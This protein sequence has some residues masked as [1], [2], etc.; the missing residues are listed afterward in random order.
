MNKTLLLIICDFLLLN[1]LALTRWE[2][3]E[4]AR[5]LEQVKAPASAVAGAVTQRD[6]L[7]AVMKGALE[8]EQRERAAVASRLDE[9]G[10]ALAEREQ[11]LGRVQTEAERLR[12]AKQTLERG[13]AD[14]SQKVD[15]ASREAGVARER[16]EAMQR[17]MAVKEAELKR[18]AAAREVAEKEAGEA[19]ARVETLS[20]AVKV[21]EREKALLTETA[22]GLRAQVEQERVERARVQETAVQLAQGVGQ[23]AQ[24]S[25]E[26]TKEVR[27]NRVLS[28][29]VVFNAYQDGRVTVRM[30]ASRPGLLGR[31][32]RSASVDT[33]LVGDGRDVHAL[34]HLDETPF[35][36]NEPVSE[37]E[38][39]SVVVARGG[40][41]VPVGRMVFLSGDPRVVALPVASGDVGKL[42]VKPFEV[43]REPFK[44]GDAVLV[45]KGVV[46]YGEVAFKLDR[47]QEGY[48]RMDNRLVKRLV[49][50]FMPKRGDLVLSRQGEFLGL[51]V[52]SDYCVVVDD[53]L[54]AKVAGVAGRTEGLEGALGEVGRRVRAMP[55]RMQ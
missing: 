43:S 13:V 52:T 51:M 36:R 38:V 25:T 12:E 4:P 21:A 44:F 16:V 46:G 7:V 34:V 28:A 45:S 8:D 37:W 11:A 50:D 48:V 19:R 55:F 24:S 17:E 54:A 2:K 27:E 9:A 49:G 14:L 39:V 20:V 31:I 1:L 26:L 47:E 18:Q 33:V 10:K 32:E 23:L 53:F 30:K 42:G 29:N 5:P 3:A 22:E 35:G 15:M 6:D 40:V 41:E